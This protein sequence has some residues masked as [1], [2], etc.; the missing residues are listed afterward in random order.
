VPYI[1]ASC[2]TGLN[3]EEAFFSLIRN[4]ESASKPGE[5]SDEEAGSSI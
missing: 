4:I 1:E 3:I 2:K 5:N